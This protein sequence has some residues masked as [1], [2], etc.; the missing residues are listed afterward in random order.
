MSELWGKHYKMT[1]VLLSDWGGGANMVQLY[2]RGGDMDI[3]E[4]RLDHR[5]TDDAAICMHLT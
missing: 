4:R 2:Q 3:V 5:G 1:L